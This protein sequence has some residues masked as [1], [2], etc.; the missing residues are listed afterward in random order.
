M[1]ELYR[2]VEMLAATIGKLQKEGRNTFSNY[3]YIK[4][5]QVLTALR[6][7]LLNH[8][9]SIVADMVDFSERD[10]TNNG[11][12]TI[13]TTV[14]MLFTITDLETGK[15]AL[16]T[17]FG[18]EQDTGGK[19]M[20]QAVSQCTKYFL[21]KLLK[22][23]D[24][25]EDGDSKTVEVEVQKR[26]LSAVISALN[27]CTTVEGIKKVFDSIPPAERPDGIVQACTARKDAITH[28][29]TWE[30]ASE[31]KKGAVHTVT[32]S[33]VSG[34]AC[35]CPQFSIKGI[36]CKHIRTHK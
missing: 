8:N 14:K 21:F 30:V 28:V 16:H 13:R 33:V 9:L 20:Q 5:E 23:T 29:M 27:Q 3:E 25:G 10:F 19:S 31:S 32:H 24:K 17:F 36:E 22:I 1:K 26:Q 12:V 4:H 34:W 2:K 6:A 11:K 7:E 35:T 15:Q 18:A